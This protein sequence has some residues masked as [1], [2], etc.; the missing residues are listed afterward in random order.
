MPY[1][2]MSNKVN[3]KVTLHI[4]GANSGDIIVAGNNSVSNLTANSAEI[5]SGAAIRRIYWATDT[6]W[7]VKRGANVVAVLTGSGDMQLDGM[8]ITLDA[9]ANVS[10][11]TS[12]ANGFLVMELSKAFSAYSNVGNY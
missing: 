6:N 2:I 4:A 1:R 7:N 9:A 12:S 8:P 10:A 5:I 11:N 3:G